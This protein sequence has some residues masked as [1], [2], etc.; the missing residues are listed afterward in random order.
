MTFQTQTYSPWKLL[1]FRLN[2]YLSYTAGI[3]G[4]NETGFQCSKLYSQIGL[5]FILSNDY[6]VFNSFQFSFS[7]Y[8]NIPDGNSIFKTNSI[9]TSD[10]GLQGFEI[11]KPILVEYR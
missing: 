7:F 6:L 4:N 2:P 11:S 5:G 9:T 1:G 10:F 8:P 3:L